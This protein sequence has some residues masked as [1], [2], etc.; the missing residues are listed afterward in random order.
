M[1]ERQNSVFSPGL[2]LH[3]CFIQGPHGRATLKSPP[4]P[5][6]IQPL[7]APKGEKLSPLFTAQPTPTRPPTPPSHYTPHPPR[8][9]SRRNNWGG[10]CPEPGRCGRSTEWAVNPV[11]LNPPGGW[12][13][14][15]PVC[16]CVSVCSCVSP[17][18]T[19][20]LKHPFLSSLLFSPLCISRSLSSI[21]I[22][23]SSGPDAAPLA[24]RLCDALI[25]GPG[26]KPGKGCLSFSLSV[27]FSPSF[28]KL[29]RN[30]QRGPVYRGLFWANGQEGPVVAHVEPANDW[31]AVN[32]NPA[33]A[34]YHRH[35]QIN[36]NK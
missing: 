7:C 12:S 6:T 19:Y 35:G 21:P 33:A 9:V 36:S 14:S 27:V 18:H 24:P 32:T 22:S 17:S 10:P 3:R 29:P 11:P 28:Y 20:T 8:G 13:G 31:V 5:D 4:R 16:V 26:R 30:R 34:D 2:S 1:V 15:L 25:G 23:S